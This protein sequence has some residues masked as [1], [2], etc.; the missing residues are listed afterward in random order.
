MTPLVII[1][2]FKS[3]EKKERVSFRQEVLKLTEMSY[4]SFYNKIQGKSD[5]T[6]SECIVI[7]QL[8]PQNDVAEG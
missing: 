6:K 7:S 1:D 2:Y 5:F 8:I 3:L 4:V